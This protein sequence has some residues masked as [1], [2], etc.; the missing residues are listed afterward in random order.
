MAYTSLGYYIFLAISVVIYYFVPLRMRWIVL[1]AA[2]IGFYCSVSGGRA[3]AFA[4]CG[5]S[6]I[7]AYLGGLALEH[8]RSRTVLAIFVAVSSLPPLD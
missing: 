7:T 8:R 6:V 2:S 1:L 5:I 3:A 4:V